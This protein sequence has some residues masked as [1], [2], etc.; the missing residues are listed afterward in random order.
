MLS[1]CSQVEDAGRTEVDPGTST[2]L[3]IGGLS[4]MVDQV[5]GH[6]ETY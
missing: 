1:M 6:L 2:V 4:E 5:T 3:A